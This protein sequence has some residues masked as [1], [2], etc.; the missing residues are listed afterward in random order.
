MTLLNRDSFPAPVPPPP[1]G[2]LH[3][4]MRHRFLVVSLV[5]VLFLG[6]LFAWG[7]R[8]GGSTPP[9]SAESSVAA[10][11]HGEPA[12][13]APKELELKPLLPAPPK[14]RP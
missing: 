4:I 6:S 8:H 13:T 1:G 2:L 9:K 3:L 5:V 12:P 7:S 11:P 10:A 14:E